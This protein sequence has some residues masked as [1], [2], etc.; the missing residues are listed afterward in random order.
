MTTTGLRADLDDPTDLENARR[1]F[2]A[3]LDPPVVRAADGRVVYDAGAFEAATAGPCPD[4]VHPS[5]WRQAGLTAVHGLFEV[6]E[7]VY[8]VRGLDLSNMT[9]IEGDTGVLVVDPLVSAETAAAAL[10]LYRAHRGDRPV[11]GV[12]YTH[13]H[14]DHFG[15]VLGVVD[16]G[17]SVPV[18][19]PE[20]FLEHAVAE[21]VYAGGAM[22]RRGVYHTGAGAG[23]PVGADGTLGAGLGP[24]TS[25]GTVGL[26]APTVDVTHTGQRETVDGI[27]L[28]F[29]LTPGTEAPAEMNFFLP[30]HRALCMAENATHTLHNVLTLR[31]A[32]VRDARMWSRYLAEAV[33]LF[34]DDTD[35]VLASH[36][37][38]TWGADAIRR[39]LGE[40]RDL[41][42]YLHDQTLR[43]M[44]QGL[45]APEIA[46][47]LELPPALD[48]AWHARGYYGSVNHDVKAVYQ[49][50]LG[51]YDGN[52]AHLWQHPP[53]P[54]AERYVECLGGVDATVARAREYAER[55]DLRF[56]AELAHHAVFAAPGHADAREV[57]ADVHT[58]LGHGSENATWRNSYL[59]AA[60]ELRHGA[61][62]MAVSAAGMASALTVT[63]LFDS[64]AIRVDGPRAWGRSAAIRWELT[65][66]DEVYAMALGNGVLVHHPT[67]RS[68]PADLTVR[69]TRAGLLR[70][71][72]GGGLD[73]VEH[74]GDAG[75]LATVLSVLGK[76]VPDFPIVTP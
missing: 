48:A 11:T 13:S 38:P 45:T 26:L 42:A 71:L 39:Y 46:E 31:G 60:R 44:N 69:L 47:V 53:E 56:A 22:L 76:P 43:L 9:V 33:E 8:Q 49:F 40:Q 5:L 65:D 19:A 67:R 23:L 72:A 63:Q 4:T 32:Q 1:G 64:L 66:L 12:L 3:T 15:G 62:P 29:H 75:A 30:R 54:L 52:P 17:T 18:L 73:G 10:G 34:V 2:V 55:G 21:N 70:L 68:G 14:I 36:H 59:T 50:Y 24:G 28:V 27:E 37:W 16:A 51:W 35:V 20:H 74:A 7:G 6:T 58:R 25:T 57:L 41:Y 61:V